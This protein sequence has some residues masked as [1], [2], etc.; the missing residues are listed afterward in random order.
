MKLCVPVPVLRDASFEI[1]HGEHPSGD[2]IP[3]AGGV[4]LFCPSIDK[5]DLFHDRLQQSA[6][7]RSASGAPQM[8]L[9][10]LK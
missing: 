7:A 6:A 4:R 2:P 1:S 3:V 9:G 8:T 5:V 10:E